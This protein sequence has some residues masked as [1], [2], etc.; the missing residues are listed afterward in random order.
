MKPFVNVQ[1][2]GPSK[3]YGKPVGFFPISIFDYSIYPVSFKTANS[4]GNTDYF[5]GF[6][7]DKLSPDGVNKDWGDVEE[8]CL[9]YALKYINTGSFRMVSSRDR[10]ND[11]LMKVQQQLDPVMKS[12]NAHKFSGMFKERK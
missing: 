8:P 11:A 7:P 4:V 3:T 5:K 6:A 12:I 9:Y 10:K 1:L 2:V